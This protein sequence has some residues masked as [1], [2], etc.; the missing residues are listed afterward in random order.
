MQHIALLCGLTALVGGVVAQHDP[1]WHT[2]QRFEW[3][4]RGGQVPPESTLQ[5]MLTEAD[6]SQSAIALWAAPGDSLRP[7]HVAC[8][9]AHL[10]PGWQRIVLLD[11]LCAEGCTLT[12]DGVASVART[13]EPVPIHI[14]P[15]VTSAHLELTSVA[16]GADLVLRVLP[17]C[18]LPLPDLPVWPMPDPE[19]PWWVGAYYGSQSVTGWALPRLGADQLFDRPVLIVEGFDPGLSDHIPMIGAGDMHWEVL[20]NCTESTY[21]DTEYLPELLDSLHLAG[22]DVVFLDF[23]DGTREVAAQSALVQEVIQ[24]CNLWKQGESP[25]VVVGASMGGLI[26]R[27][28]L[29]TLEAE[30]PSPCT[31]LFVALDSPF[32]GAYLPIALQQAIHGLAGIS[33]AAHAMQEALNTPA[34]REL[35]AAHVGSGLD[36]FEALQTLLATQGLP[37]HPLNLAVSNG[38]PDGPSLV[39]EGPLLQASAELVGWEWAH[40]DLFALPGNPDHPESTSNA[41]ITCDLELPEPAPLEAGN[42]WHTYLATA[43]SFAPAWESLPGSTSNH[44]E[45]LAGALE[46]AGL[47]VTALQTPGLFIPARSA[48]DLDPWE[49]ASISPFDAVSIQPTNRPSASHCDVK[50]HLSTLLEWILRGDAFLDT[51]DSTQALLAY[52]DELQ[53]SRWIPGTH[54]YGP[55]GVLLHH[56]AEL[57]PCADSIVFHAGSTLQVG[58]PGHPAT[59]HLPADAA[60]VLEPGSALEIAPASAIELHPGALLIL[61][62]ATADLLEDGALIIHEG[63]TLRLLDASILQFNDESSRIHLRGGRIEAEGET[64]IK[65]AGRIR[66][67]AFSTVS[68]AEAATLRVQGIHPEHTV[69]ELTSDAGIGVYGPG[70]LQVA[71]GQTKIGAGATLALHTRSV[72]DTTRIEG[73]YTWAS[74]VSTHRMKASF[75]AFDRIW[76]SQTHASG[77][78][79]LATA[80]TFEDSRLR[81]DSSGFRFNDCSFLRSPIS[82]VAVAFPSRVNACSFEGESA[83][84]SPMLSLQACPTN[85]TVESSR[86]ESGTC[87]IAGEAE[88][89][90]VTCSVF[91]SLDTGISGGMGTILSMEDDA[92]NEFR[93]NRVHLAF[94]GAPPPDLVQGGSTFGPWSEALMAGTWDAPCP[95]TA[96]HLVATG[97]AWWGNE[98]TGAAVN[99]LPDVTFDDANCASAVFAMDASPVVPRGCEDEEGGRPVSEAVFTKP[100]FEAVPEV[101]SARIV[102]NPATAWV[103]LMPPDAWGLAHWDWRAYDPSGRTIAGSTYPGTGTVRVQTTDWKPG[104]YIIEFRCES[105]NPSRELC[106]LIVQ[107]Q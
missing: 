2:Q 34:A 79:F 71:A 84:E 105:G 78:A 73:P 72:W 95:N 31:R 106:P 10:Y 98:G 90:R 104:A 103:H 49:T 53:R 50:D 39:G 27:H 66:A 65:G 7:V 4:N 26:V 68:I 20:W 63:A 59:L 18:D 86:F 25:L 5:R 17:P 56:D 89:I 40:V 64:S 77:G 32:R 94:Q 42:L 55:G 15:S 54:F 13:G 1:A 33:A 47:S 11:T 70:T 101:A 52:T 83:D 43:P 100:R 16:G 61:A 46:T 29:A 19:N 67:E 82:A 60:L 74:L 107:P 9:R 37:E 99:P 44:L 75:A 69:L 80:C 36:D 97:N 35:L 93:D 48:L 21:P 24:L 62:T 51:P 102:P 23:S 45:A 76:M 81:I 85:V 8:S 58:A 14:G 41:F 91:R 88:R 92:V 12:V 87:G 28:A 6:R 96:F 38:R 30:G 22:Y 57:A 3:R